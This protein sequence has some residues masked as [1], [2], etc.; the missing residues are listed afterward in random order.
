[1]LTFP[2]P[3]ADFWE[4]LKVTTAAPWRLTDIAVSSRTDDGQSFQSTRGVP[5]WTSPV[6]LAARPNRDARAIQ[7]RIEVMARNGETFL[8]Y[9]VTAPGPR[10]DPDGAIL[11]AAS[12]AV[13]GVTVPNAFTTR[14][15]GLPAGYV[16]SA[17]DM[18]SILTASGRRNLARVVD[19]TVTA[20]GAGLTPVFQIEPGRFAEGDVGNSVTLI[21][22][23]A[24]FK[25]EP[26]SFDPGTQDGVNTLGAGFQ[27]TQVVT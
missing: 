21:K 6:V 15:S 12:P 7:T 17:G 23:L 22:P 20:D 27:V 5:L 14:V 10:L 11:G 26:G 4:R 18:L 3:V 9:D 13:A 24:K 2:L 8:A 25:I 19:D 1:M 16:L